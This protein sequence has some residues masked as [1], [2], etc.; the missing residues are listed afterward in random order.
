M[1]R[2]R[3]CGQVS[4]ALGVIG[5]ALQRARSLIE[6]LDDACAATLGPSEAHNELLS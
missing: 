1:L 3:T 4:L 6:A 2:V 5:V